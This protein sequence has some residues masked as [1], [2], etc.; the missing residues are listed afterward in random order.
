MLAGE[1]EGGGGGAAAEAGEE[2]KLAA[3]AEQAEGLVF[4]HRKGRADEKYL[5]FVRGLCHAVKGD[6][7]GLR[8][9]LLRG[10]IEPALGEFFMAA[11]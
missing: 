4:A 5:S 10:E 6:S 11:K 2:T 7:H 1:G 9:R 3:V 8:A